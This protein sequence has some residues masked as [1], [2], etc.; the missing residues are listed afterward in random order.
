MKLF[1]AIR[2]LRKPQVL[3]VEG[4]G[5]AGP[6]AS[7][8]AA[9][10]A[11]SAPL[12]SKHVFP[13]FGNLPLYTTRYST[14]SLREDREKRETAAYTG[15]SCVWQDSPQCL[16]GLREDKPVSAFEAVYEV[17]WKS[18]SGEGTREA[19]GMRGAAQGV[20]EV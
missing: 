10:P 16:E 17:P 11:T 3:V 18:V 4:A 14:L 19:P 5:L 6:G 15:P 13:I 1:P 8:G 2:Y 20:K 12:E 7:G 9:V